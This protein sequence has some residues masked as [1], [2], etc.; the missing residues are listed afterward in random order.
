MTATSTSLPHWDMSTIYPS[1]ESAEF[2]A[3]FADVIERIA[4]LE[5]L[6]AAQDVK[7]RST[8]AVDSTLV[9]AFELVTSEFNGVLEAVNTLSAYISSFI[10][11]NSRD[12]LAQ[13][14]MSELQSH[15]VRLSQLGTRW[16]AWIGSLDVGALIAQSALAAAHSFALE[17]ASIQSGHL[18]S[19]AEEALVSELSLSS[20]MAWSKLYGNLTSQMVVAME[21]NGATESLPISALRNL[22]YDPDRAVRRRAYE[23]ELSAWQSVTTPLAAAL[24]SIKGEVN[25]LARQRGWESPLAEA[26][27]EN[28]IDRQTLDAM[29]SAARESFADFRRYLRAKARALGLES[30]A[31]YDLFAPVGQTTT[32]WEYGQARQFI[33]AQFATYSSK[34][35]E[36]AR[37]AFAEN[38]IDAEPRDGKRDGAFCMSVRGDESRILS[39]YKSA[40]GGMSTLAH[41][42]GHGYH[43]VNL[44][45][46]TPLQRS[47]PM[48]MAETAS[49][50]CE[51]IIRHAALDAADPLEQIAILDASLQGACQVVVDI[52]SRFLF[53]QR[54]F[55]GR[56]RR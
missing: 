5:E 51:T 20:G 12:T 15:T 43:N 26:L 14:R 30:L 55:E 52:Y 22:A 54:V 18:M 16:V 49:I 33:V 10:A 46:R 4:A 1:L 44:A 39:N 2:G 7:Q 8:S 40:F 35:S 21:H 23:A 28:H 34:L 29:L 27:F 41:E 48:T 50:F 38:W 11:T 36:Y 13:A 56:Q 42:L 17:Q 6:F 3:A 19:P 25:T 53:E 45:R 31:W 32:V 37:R 24:N 9:R 47:T